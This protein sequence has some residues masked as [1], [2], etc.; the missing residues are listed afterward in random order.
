MLVV[1]I[2]VLVVL[3]CVKKKG[4]KKNHSTS[5]GVVTQDGGEADPEKA[6]PSVAAALDEPDCPSTALSTDLRPPIP[7]GSASSSVAA[8]QPTDSPQR[9]FYIRFSSSRNKMGGRERRP[10]SPAE[11]IHDYKAPL[12]CS[13]KRQRPTYLKCKWMEYTQHTLPSPPMSHQ[14]PALPAPVVPA[15]PGSTNVDHL[16]PLTPPNRAPHSGFLNAPQ[17]RPT[18]VSPLALQSQSSFCGEDR[19]FYVELTPLPQGQDIRM[20]TNAL[21]TLRQ[22]PSGSGNDSAVETSSSASSIQQA[23]PQPSPESTTPQLLT[24]AH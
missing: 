19:S 3:T 4:C 2:V 10:A 9:Q 16:W 8:P 23:S 20:Q 12:H 11:S 1:F 15:H 24:S 13:L 17:V 6:A 22:L 7:G 5:S 21:A 14:V 18:K